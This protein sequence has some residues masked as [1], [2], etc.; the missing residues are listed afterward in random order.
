MR[1]EAPPGQG[2]G[3]K[4]LTIGAQSIRKRCAFTI[5]SVT[6]HF[7][8]QM[9]RNSRLLP[10]HPQRRTQQLI[11]R[12]VGRSVLVAIADRNVRAEYALASRLWR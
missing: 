10:K 3:R 1:C 4:H 8:S 7:P 2:D 11:G 6:L 5:F 9:L 12:K